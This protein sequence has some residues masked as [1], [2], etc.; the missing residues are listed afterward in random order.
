VLHFYCLQSLAFDGVVVD[1]DC[2]S[3]IDV[4][5]SRRLGMSKFFEAY[6]HDFGLLCI[7]KEGTEFGFPCRGSNKLEDYAGDVD[8]AVDEDRVA[9]TWN[10]AKEE[11]ATSA[12]LCLWGATIGSIGMDVEDHVGHAE[13]NFGIRMCRHIIKNWG[14]HLLVSSLGLF[15]WE[16]IA[17]R[18]MRIVGSTVCA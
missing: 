9:I 1:A 13:S 12:T 4:N 2:G 10:A 11:V 5:G 18:A 17:E 3:I 8:S 15:C 6:L 14:T 16:V 7:E